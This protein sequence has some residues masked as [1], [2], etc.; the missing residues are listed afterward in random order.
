MVVDYKGKLI[1]NPF[2]T[3][4]VIIDLETFDTSPRAAI[5]AAGLVI[6]SPELEVKVREEYILID[7]FRTPIGDSRFASYKVTESTVDRWLSEDQEIAKQYLEDRGAYNSIRDMLNDISYTIRQCPKDD[8]LV[9][10]YPS[11]FDIPILAHA[12]AKTRTQLP[13]KY[14]QSACLRTLKRLVYPSEEQ[15]GKFDGIKH[16]PLADAYHEAKELI[17]ILSYLRE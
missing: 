11:D 17:H 16:T 7:P 2:N 8:F 13:W 10:G 5:F 15:L 1:I 6:L 4:H 9:Y 3:H 12:Y 14:H